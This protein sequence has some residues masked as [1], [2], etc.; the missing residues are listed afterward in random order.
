MRTNTSAHALQRIVVLMLVGVLAHGSVS[1][2]LRASAGQDT[3][4]ALW[5]GLPE[6]PAGALI[7]LTLADGTQLSGRLVEARADA[8]ILGDTVL[9]KGRLVAAAGSS[10]KDPFTFLRPHVASITVAQAKRGTH[11]ALLWAGGMVAGLAV[12][13]WLSAVDSMCPANCQ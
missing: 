5:D 12:L 13:S 8:V 2:A 10:L 6:L 1:D 11:K 9:V 4:A 7:Q 3:L